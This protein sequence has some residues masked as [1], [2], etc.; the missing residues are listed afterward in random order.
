MDKPPQYS[1]ATGRHKSVA[2]MT[3]EER[4]SSLQAFAE[5]QKYIQP[6]G[7]EILPYN[8]TSNEGGFN[9]VIFGNPLQGP[10][11]F[12]MA[13]DG[14]RGSL[15]PPEYGKTQPQQD[16]TTKPK[17]GILKRLLGKSKDGENKNEEDGAQK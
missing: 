12:K 15:P 16:D 6:G 9:S 7:G 11:S 2:E 17:H 1:T 5:E 10:T 8:S 3:P 13:S 4:L 14:Y